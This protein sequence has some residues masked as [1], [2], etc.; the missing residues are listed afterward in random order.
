[1][2]LTSYSIISLKSFLDGWY[3]RDAN[4]IV[5]NDLMDGF[6]EWVEKKYNVNTSQ[7]WSHIILFYSQDE[8][9]A[10]DRFFELFDSWLQISKNSKS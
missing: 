3:Q 6:Q 2:Y 4:T 8:Y 9:D 5:D 1:M 10:L 7:S